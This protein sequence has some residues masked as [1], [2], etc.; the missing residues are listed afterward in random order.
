M[1]CHFN[2]IIII[3]MSSTHINTIYHVTVINNI[4]IITEHITGQWGI[5][6]VSIITISSVKCHHTPNTSLPIP[7]SIITHTTNNNRI[8]ISIP[9]HHQYHH[10]NGWNKYYQN[11]NINNN[12]SLY[13]ILE[14]SI[15]VSI[16]LNN[17]TMVTITGILL[18]RLQS[19]F[20]SLHHH[21]QL[22]GQ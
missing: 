22:M 4:I 1:A 13:I 12:A 14:L 8:S 18:N 17:I 10:F 7:S 3:I 5:M 19:S 11:I 16:I 2:T 6:E 15:I 20:S 21:H 9:A